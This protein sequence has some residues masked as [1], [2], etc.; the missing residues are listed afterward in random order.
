[1]RTNVCQGKTNIRKNAEKQLQT[2]QKADKIQRLDI[3]HKGR[4]RYE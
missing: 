2:E 1:M 3:E 4:K